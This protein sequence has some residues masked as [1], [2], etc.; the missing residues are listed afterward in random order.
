MCGRFSLTAN[1]AELNLRFQLAGGTAP[2]VPRYNGA[3]TQALAVI[4]NTE[5][6]RLSYL[7]WGL[8]PPWA[9]DPSAGSKMI[10]ARAETI[11][12]KPSFRKPL[13][14][15]RC[16]VPSDGFFEWKQDAG[17]Q[18][19]RIFLKNTAV[20]SMAGIWE[21]WHSPDGEILET[22]SIITTEANAF[23]KNIHDRMPVILKPE[24]EKNWLNAGTE[25]EILELL[26]PFDPEQMDAFPVSR[27]VNS[28]R[29][30]NPQVCLPQAEQ[31]TL[32]S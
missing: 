24:D 8:I 27:L 7:R 3:P 11:A 20:F 12:E 15:R 21:R 6:S 30:E 2:Y 22:F 25:S 19:Y 9:K 1:E 26:R 18:P 10:N 16:L 32:F 4:T 23:M 5:P 28:V 14:G 31:N 13:L 17:K 29:N